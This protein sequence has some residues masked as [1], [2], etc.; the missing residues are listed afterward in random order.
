MNKILALIT[1]LCISFSLSRNVCAEEQEVE[2][3][4]RYSKL[5]EVKLLE[6]KLK[7]LNLELNTLLNE[8]SQ[9][10]EKY[11]SLANSEN[12]KDKKVIESVKKSW[13]PKAERIKELRNSIYYYRR[14][15]NAAESAKKDIAEEQNYIR[16]VFYNGFKN[17]F[18]YGFGQKASKYNWLKQNADMILDYDWYENENTLKDKITEM[19]KAMKECQ[20][21][22]FAEL[23]QNDSKLKELEEKKQVEAIKGDKRLEVL[24]KTIPEIKACR[25]Q[26]N[27]IAKK[28]KNKNYTA[29]ELEQNDLTKLTEKYNKVARKILRQEALLAR[30]IDEEWSNVQIKCQEIGEM[31]RKRLYEK[32]FSEK[33]DSFEE[34]CSL[35][36]IKLR[37]EAQLGLIKLRRDRSLKSKKIGHNCTDCKH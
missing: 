30:E 7:E 4:Y 6:K 37:S 25:D 31:Q 17:H 21:T 15:A 14:I 20:D 22:A 32:W 18:M 35:L 29:E 16:R 12:D 10:R 13:E 11:R 3:F 27:K 1:I 23:W 33:H 2:R 36:T 9:L 28:I 34:Y 26:Y 24:G 5:P 8:L 19:D